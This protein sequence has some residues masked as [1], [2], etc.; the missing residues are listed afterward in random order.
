VSAIE[1]AVRVIVDL[2]VRGQYETV[3]RMT[4]ARR[5]GADQLAAAISSYGRQLVEPGP[6]WWDSV[7]ITPI[8]AADRPEF[9]V[10]AP[11]WTVEEGRS[12]LTLELRLVEAA[13]Q[14]YESEVLDLHV[15]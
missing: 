14:V 9:H 10:A 1:T 12:D 15:A 8:D 6:S 7:T 11:L 2:L 4:R 3:E 13:S 5:L